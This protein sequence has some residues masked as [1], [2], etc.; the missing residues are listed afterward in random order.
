MFFFSE[1]I[2]STSNSSGQATFY[3]YSQPEYKGDGTIFLY[4]LLFFHFSFI[5][6]FRPVI[7]PNQGMACVTSCLFSQFL[8]FFNKFGDALASLL[9]VK[10]VCGVTFPIYGLCNFSHLCCASGARSNAGTQ[11]GSLNTQIL[12]FKYCLL[13]M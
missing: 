7:T 11:T 3:T 8:I 6:F 13:K 2:F 12:V 5:F 9:W 4:I 10:D 1:D